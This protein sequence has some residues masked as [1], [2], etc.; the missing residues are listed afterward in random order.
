MPS[1][2]GHALRAA[3]ADNRRGL[4]LERVAQA[5]DRT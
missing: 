1:E 4:I 5:H 2:S 3:L